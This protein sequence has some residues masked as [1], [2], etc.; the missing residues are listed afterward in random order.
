MN[1]HHLNLRL[2]TIANLIPPNAKLADVGTD[3]GL[4]PIRL[5]QENRISMAIATDIRQGPL[6]RGKANAVQ[7]GVNNISFR[8]CN[9]LEAVA[10]HEVDTVVIAGMGGENIVDILNRAPWCSQGVRLILQPMSRPEVLRSSLKELGLRILSETLVEDAGRLY[11]VIA[12]EGGTAEDYTP[13]ELYTGLFSHVQDQSLFPRLLRE[14]A[15]RLT[16]AVNG[17]AA[18][19]KIEDIQRRDALKT[20]LEGILGAERG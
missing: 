4:L 10:P 18:S 20:A 2:A 17:L 12:A 7:H 19:E 6:D 14:Q 9:G 11:S 8:L 5:L 1:V 15:M 16:P 13:A 3:H